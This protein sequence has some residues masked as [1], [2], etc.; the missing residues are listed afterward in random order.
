MSV[1]T[2]GGQSLILPWL[3]ICQASYRLQANLAVLQTRNT[4]TRV[5]SNT[6]MV[7]SLR[8]REARTLR[9]LSDDEIIRLFVLQRTDK[10]QINYYVVCCKIDYLNKIINWFSLAYCLSL[11]SF[12]VK[13]SLLGEIKYLQKRPAKYF[14]KFAKQ[15][16]TDIFI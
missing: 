12:S 14:G 7:R 2:Q 8:W 5:S 13:M 3:Y 6:D 4:M 16:S 10:D 11:K 15:I 9:D 1:S